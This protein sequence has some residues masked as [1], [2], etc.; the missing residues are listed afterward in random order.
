MVRAS[1]R[2]DV[3][4]LQKSWSGSLEPERWIQGVHVQPLAHL[5]LMR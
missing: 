3:R 5:L 1:A 4:A 2:H